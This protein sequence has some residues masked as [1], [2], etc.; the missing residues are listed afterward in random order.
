MHGPSASRRRVIL[1]SLTLPFLPLGR[2]LAESGCIPAVTNILGPAY[3]KGAPF[4][5]RLCAADEPGTPLAMQGRIVDVATCKPLD[6]AV[7]DVWQVD[8]QGDYDMSSDAFHL[9]GKF[10]T[11]AKGHYAFDTIMPVPYGV[12]P[13]HIHCLVTREGYEPRITQIYFEGDDRNATDRYVKKELVIAPTLRKSGGLDGRFDVALERERAAETDAAHAYGEY[14]GTYQVAPGVTI[15]VSVA[16]KRLRWH[17]SAAETDGEAIDG[18]FAPRAKG[19]FF[20][21][22]YDFEVSFVRNDHGIV[23][24]ALDSRGILFQKLG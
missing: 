22:E 3:R 17:L 13:K 10:R 2:A 7:M 19:R 24:H 20:V 6:G 23:D 14:A 18:E 12:R 5:A 16:G 15:V 4:R 21:P 8:A 1:A 11:D 9:R